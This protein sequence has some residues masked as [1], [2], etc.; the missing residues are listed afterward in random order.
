[1]RLIAIGLPVKFLGDLI[2]STEIPLTGN[3]DLHSYKIPIHLKSENL[4]KNI[5]EM[6]EWLSDALSEEQ[7]FLAATT[8]GSHLPVSPAS[9]DQ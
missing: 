6:A 9:G 3:M 8:G 1:M 4:F 2:S 7:V 5:R